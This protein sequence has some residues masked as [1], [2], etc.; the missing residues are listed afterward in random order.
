MKVA[1]LVEDDQ[2]AASIEDFVNAG[3]FGK[4]GQGLFN[5]L[6]PFVSNLLEPKIH[7]PIIDKEALRAALAVAPLFAPQSLKILM[8]ARPRLSPPH[9]RGG[10]AAAVFYRHA[11]G[12]VT[13][14]NVVERGEKVTTPSACR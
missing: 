1:G 8:G 10:V 2:F 3:A 11:D 7:A 5:E 6:L 13:K 14:L 12:V 4:R 9:Q